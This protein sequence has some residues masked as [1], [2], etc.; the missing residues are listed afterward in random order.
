MRLQ[1]ESNEKQVKEKVKKKSTSKKLTN[2]E[3]IYKKLSKNYSDKI[4]FIYSD[5]TIQISNLQYNHIINCKPSYISTVNGVVD[6]DSWNELLMYLI[7]TF[8]VNSLNSSLRKDIEDN[9]KSLKDSDFSKRKINLEN[10]ENKSRDKFILALAEYEITQRDFMVDKIF[11]KLDFE[12]EI[13]AYRLYDTDYYIESCMSTEVIFDVIVKTLYA[14]NMNFDECAVHLVNNGDTDEVEE[15][16]LKT[17]VKTVDKMYK[18]GFNDLK[19]NREVIS[20]IFSGMDEEKFSNNT[21]VEI[22]TKVAYMIFKFITDNYGIESIKELTK[23]RGKT[24]LTINVNM[25][26]GV[27]FKKDSDIIYG[28]TD[29]NFK[30]LLEFIDLAVKTLNINKEYIKFKYKVVDKSK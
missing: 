16:H 13:K 26:N 15:L 30:G 11:G 12:K 8:R 20:A 14:L 28:Y 23:H 17:V 3:K 27:E 24:R 21:D 2:T 22:N 25:G 29:S 5:V 4:K 6:V 7:D 9:K 18:S 19:A 10:N 1:L